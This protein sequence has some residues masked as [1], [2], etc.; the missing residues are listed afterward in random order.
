MNTTKTIQLN[1]ASDSKNT[2][3][4]IVSLLELLKISKE[5]YILPNYDAVIISLDDYEDMLFMSNLKIQKELN[6]DLKKYKETGGIDYF[7]YRKKR[8]LKKTVI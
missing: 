8:L 6:Q 2:L 1:T 7:E 5:R 4:K 3:S